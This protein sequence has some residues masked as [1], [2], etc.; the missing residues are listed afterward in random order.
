MSR[1]V[2]SRAKGLDALRR[3]IE[4]VVANPRMIAAAASLPNLFSLKGRMPRAECAFP[5][6]IIIVNPGSAG[7]RARGASR[8]AATTA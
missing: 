7:C 6:I 3:G 4:I 1:I 2:P 8:A 5:V